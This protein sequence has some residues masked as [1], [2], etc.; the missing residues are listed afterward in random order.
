MILLRWT[1]RLTGLVS[2]IILARLLVPSDFG[3]VAMAMFVVGLLEML[4]QSGQELAIIRHPNPTRA[5]YDTA[6]TLSVIVGVVI[7]LSIWGAAP[8]AAIYFHEPRVKPVMDFLALR[9]F[10][11]GMENIGIIDFRRDLEFNRFFRYNIFP[12]IVA[13]IVTIGGAIIFRNYW[14]LVAG[15]IAAQATKIT[16]SFLMHSYRPRLSLAKLS[17][18]G[19]FS[20]W[21]LVQETGLY[22]NQQIDQIMVGGML[23]SGAM[24]RYAVAT[25][26]ASSPSAE[27]NVPMVAVLYPVMSKA[28]NDQ[29]ARRNL[30]LHV[31]SWSV[32]I[33]FSTAVGITMVAQDL[34]HLVLGQRWLDVE[35]LI[36]WLALGTGVLGLSSGAY[37]TFDAIGKPY[38][39]ARMQWTRVTLLVIALIPIFFYFRSTTAVAIGRFGMIA[40][41]IPTLLL[42]VGREIGV[43]L[44]DYLNTIWRPAAASSSMALLLS[45]TNEYLAPGNVRLFM[46]IAL[47]AAVFAGVLLSAWRLSGRPNGPEKDVYDALIGISIKL[48]SGRLGRS[49]QNENIQETSFS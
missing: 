16:M 32:V 3:I 45:I 30:Y 23:G 43:G 36:G 8:I 21:T 34:V 20:M 31:F 39:G 37:A 27:I 28:A 1:V 47:G 5:D 10:L 7:A 48:R 9:S 19:S 49:A 46:D 42:T 22:L 12:K 41:F 11:G 6:W 33:C 24:G 18:M 17:E 29:A 26:L 13:F 40:I 25:D 4:N 38:L 15:I 44:N 14:A 2:T 35:P